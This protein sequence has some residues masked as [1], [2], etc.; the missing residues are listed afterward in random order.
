MKTI[1]NKLDK[2]G[3]I[4]SIIHFMIGIFTDR[5]FFNV[6][7]IGTDYY[8]TA[9]Y[10]ILKVMYLILL[11]SVWQI[12]L[13]T[14]R[15]IKQKDKSIINYLEI[16]TVYFIIMMVFLGLTWPGVWRGNEFGIL[17]GVVDFHI[18]IWQ[19]YLTSIFYTLC[20][21]LIPIPSG[22]IIIQNICISLVVGYIIHKIYCYTGRLKFALLMYIP[23]LM[24]PIIDQNLYPIRN[25][26][27]GYIEL[28]FLFNILFFKYENR[29][30]EKKNIAM[31][32][33]LITIL[34]TW[35][36]EGIY[37]IVLGTSAILLL[38]NK[39]FEKECKSKFIIMVLILTAVFYL[40]QK[41]FIN[42]AFGDK[43]EISSIISPI[44]DVVKSEVEKTTNIKTK[45]DT[46]KQQKSKNNSNGKYK[47]AIKE[48]ISKNED[49]SNIDKV[50][51]VE[52]LLENENGLNAY[53]S[54]NKTLIREVYTSNEYSKF[55]KSYLKLIK[56]NF[57]A[58]LNER[59]ELFM[60]TNAQRDWN[61][62]VGNTANLYSKKYNTSKKHKAFREG[63][64]TNPINI[65]LRKNTILAL[66]CGTKDYKANENFKY[67]YNLIPA[68]IV[69][70]IITIG[71]L[72]M[73][74]YAIT[75][76]SLLTLIRIPL[77]FATA[78]RAL[79]MYYFSIYLIG[80][81]LGFLVIWSFLYKI[82]NKNKEIT[83]KLEV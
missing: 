79:F 40:P 77:V 67:I 51:D 64:Y 42:M 27:Y 53:W 83:T 80:T 69:L 18:D 14:L 9:V 47:K 50:L 57:G 15:K 41:I 29:K 34:S 22:I 49:L 56:N 1:I 46:T 10:I 19:H 11:V 33:V 52:F 54:K 31:F 71:S 30:I 65:E 75:I 20:L 60:K 8:S 7:V 24:I 23:F 55:K 39:N 3:F 12:I 74:K 58:F 5:L 25:T 61:I 13:S 63:L 21:M 17:N 68:I 2:T 16:S 66:E 73:K 59:G 4:I 70:V 38:F 82:I 26:L 81:V 36:S 48:T 78:P 72:F 35:R 44:Y 28:F 6:Q 62:F 32:A 76:V 43:Y 45:Q 37:Y